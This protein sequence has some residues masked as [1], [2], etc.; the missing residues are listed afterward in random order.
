[1]LSVNTRELRSLTSWASSV[2]GSVLTAMTSGAAFGS[3]TAAPP[4]A[5]VVAG[6]AVVAAAVVG[7]VVTALSV[8]GVDF[9]L[10]VFVAAVADGMTAAA[11]M[12]I[13]AIVAST[14]VEA[15]RLPRWFG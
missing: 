14:I 7:V 1:M 6:A 5:A 12:L 13:S 15:F 2:E 4:R 3:C 9:F 8:V 10:V 11:P